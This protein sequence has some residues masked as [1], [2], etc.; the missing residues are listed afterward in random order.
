MST[1]DFAI[2]A[3]PSLLPNKKY[4]DITGLPVRV[5]DPNLHVL[6]LSTSRELTQHSYQ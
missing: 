4:C 5:P 3:P 2:E 6:Y 1:Q